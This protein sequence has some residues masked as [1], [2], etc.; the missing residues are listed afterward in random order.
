MTIY[1]AENS[2]WLIGLTEFRMPDPRWAID[3]VTGSRS[4]SISFQLEPWREA[5]E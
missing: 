4:T 2:T 3:C 1:P 5:K